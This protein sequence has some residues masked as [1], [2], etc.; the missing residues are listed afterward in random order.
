MDLEANVFTRIEHFWD[1]KQR[2]RGRVCFT[3]EAHL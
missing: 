1:D 3:H 2:G